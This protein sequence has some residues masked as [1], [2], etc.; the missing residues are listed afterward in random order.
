MNT[1]LY[2]I[3][4]PEGGRISFMGSVVDG[5]TADVR[6]R[7]E[8]NPHPDTEPSFNTEVVTVSG[9]DPMLYEIMIEPQ[10]ENTYS[11]FI[12]YIDTRDVTVTITDVVVDYGTPPEL[13]VM[14]G[15]F[16]GFVADGDTFTF[17][18]GAQDWAGV[19]NTNADL[20]PLH[21]GEGGEVRFRAAIPEV[22]GTVAEAKPWVNEINYD[23]EG[24][25]SGEF[26]EFAAPEGFDATGWRFQL[27]NGTTGAV[28]AA[29]QLVNLTKT[30]SGGLDLYVVNRNAGGLRNGPDGV[31]VINPGPDGVHA[32]ADD[33]CE[34]LVSYEGVL[35]NAQGLCVGV[36][37]V[38]ITPNQEGEAPVGQSLQ[39]TGTGSSY[40]D[41]TWVAA[42]NTNGAV[43]D[44]QTYGATSV[45][46]PDTNIR[47][48]FEA[49]PY[50]NNNPSVGTENV[51]I[52]GGLADYSVQIPPQDAAQ[53]FNSFLMYIVER[54]QSVMVKDIEVVM[55]GDGPT[56]P[57]D[58]DGDGVLDD[59]D[60]FPNDPTET[61]D[62]DGDGIG[63]NADLDN[64]NDGVIDAEDA[65]PFDSNR[66]V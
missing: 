13:A 64:D 45:A 40:A 16:D 35:T 33:S 63:N 11:S 32:T 54:D 2:P 1:E 56:E 30:T 46:G 9:S 14:D 27:I 34:M 48:V 23:P 38:E 65:F 7:F 36:T 58:T 31:A 26:V 24:T 53:E 37:S 41:F 3:D 20:Y 17:P 44:G 43:N 4:F 10:G 15:V 59:E 22:E 57:M 51:L 25:D 55:Y 62:S 29:N 5:G 66:G 19:A 28:Y 60:A 61:L 12:M 52:S 42:A 8:K 21:F 6:F 47:F 39:L 50:P 49:N 18:T